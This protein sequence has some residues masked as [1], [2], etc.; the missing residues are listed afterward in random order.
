MRVAVLGG[1]NHRLA[2][3]KDH[4][5]FWH[6]EH[7]ADVLADFERN[8]HTLV[9]PGA[10]QNLCF[11]LDHSAIFHKRIYLRNLPRPR[12]VGYRKICYLY[13]VIGVYMRDFAFQKAT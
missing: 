5:S 3:A 13:F 2:A 1:E 6:G 10:L 11:H 7:I 12:L 8:I 9:Q 4:R